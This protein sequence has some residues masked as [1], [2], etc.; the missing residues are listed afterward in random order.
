MMKILLI[1][2]DGLGDRP[3]AELGNKTPLEAARAPNL[4][5]MAQQGVC[6]LITPFLFP[7]EK[8]PTSEGTHIALFGF[9]NYFLGRGPYEA[10]GVGMKMNAGDVALRVNFATVGKNLKII[11]RRANR[12]ERTRPFIDALS[13]I[14][15]DGVK[16][17]IKKSFGHRAVLVLRC[18]TYDVKH[19][20]AE[21]SDNDSHKNKVKIKKIIP[22]NQSKEAKFT[23]DVLNEYLSKAEHIL[24]DHPLNKKRIKQGLL[25]ANYLLV[26]GAGRFKETPSFKKRY[27]LKAACVAGGGL[28][29]GVAKIL[30]MDLIKVKGATGMA[31][32]NLK[33]KFRVAKNALCPV[34]CRSA[35][36]SPKAKLFNRVK[37][38]DF[39]FLHIK[40]TDT[41]A[42]DND[43]I[44]KKDFI[45]KI[46]K[47]IK[48]ILG[49]KNTI[50][51]ITADHSTSCDLKRHCLEPIPIL[52]YGDGK[53]NVSQFSERACAKGKLKKIKQTCLMPK[54]LDLAK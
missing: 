44:G 23:A 33:A 10:M 8:I 6:G 47:N 14:K 7:G 26:R 51:A 34:K 19:L 3:I 11:D 53:D 28:Y 32:T 40:A 37:K 16:F 2:I 46:D 18:L 41:F 29:K 30:G 45:E 39:V 36:I 50:I 54:I 38:Y 15:I 48:S 5:Y 43:F 21:I 22:L 42:H 52:I 49:L 35:A 1:I 31:D 12:I 27:N 9:Q 20:S 13:D 25:A 4:D 17:L 24:E